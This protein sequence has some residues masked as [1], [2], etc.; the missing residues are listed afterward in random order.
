MKEFGLVTFAVVSP[1]LLPSPP[2][3]ASCRCFWPRRWWP[4]HIASVLGLGHDYIPCHGVGLP[5]FL[6][7]TCDD[8]MP[9]HP[10][11]KYRYSDSVHTL[12]HT[13][14][15]TCPSSPAEF[16]ELVRQPLSHSTWPNNSR[17]LSRST[18]WA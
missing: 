7:Q 18:N 15:G 10:L 5:L 9:R 4:W 8:F 16:H 12:D 3:R 13:F 2:S 6:V 14:V 11:H 17:R 1:V